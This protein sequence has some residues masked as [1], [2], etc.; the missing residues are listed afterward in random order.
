MENNMVF[1]VS[2][3]YVASTFLPFRLALTELLLAFFF[4]FMVCGSAPDTSATS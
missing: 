2:Y 3:R 4:T 1:G